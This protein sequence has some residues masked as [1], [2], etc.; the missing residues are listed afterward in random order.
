MLNKRQKWVPYP[1]L[2]TI[3]LLPFLGTRN[4]RV[5]SYPSTQENRDSAAPNNVPDSSTMREVSA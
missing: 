4:I 3:L 5:D 2:K 1:S